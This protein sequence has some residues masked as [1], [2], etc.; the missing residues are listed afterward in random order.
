MDFATDFA[1]KHHLPPCDAVPLY[2]RHLDGQNPTM[3]KL[4]TFI[5][6]PARPR[7]GLHVDMLLQQQHSSIPNS[8]TLDLSQNEFEFRIRPL[9]FRD[10]CG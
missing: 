6:R 5:M 4:K 3:T 9:A 7:R 2:I 8:S 1:L 10:G